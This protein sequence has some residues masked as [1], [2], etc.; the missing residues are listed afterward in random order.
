MAE[1][2]AH[3]M[4]NAKPVLHKFLEDKITEASKVGKAFK[5]RIGVQLITGRAFHGMLKAGV[6]DVYRITWRSI[7]RLP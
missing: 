6:A 2:T 5:V 7:W 1:F 4:R 3:F